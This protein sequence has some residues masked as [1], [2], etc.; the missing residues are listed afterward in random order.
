MV[1]QCID[2]LIL[3]CTGHMGDCYSDW[4][5]VAGG[6]YWGTPTT[7]ELS[8]SPSGGTG[9]CAGFNTLSVFG[10]GVEKQARRSAARVSVENKVRANSAAFDIYQWTHKAEEFVCVDLSRFP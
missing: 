10:P 8:V 1:T 3:Q 9:H 6:V 5:V 2:G 4:R 7:P